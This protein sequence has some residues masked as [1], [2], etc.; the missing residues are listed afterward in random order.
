MQLL[1]IIVVALVGAIA[2]A[3][4][5]FWA[6][7]R[8]SEEKGRVEA[9]DAIRKAQHEDGLRRLKNAL[10]ADAASRA[11]SASNGMFDHDDGFRRD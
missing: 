4:F 10:E 1:L 6:M 11:D 7:V 3:Y 2:V 8:A 5:V 9:A